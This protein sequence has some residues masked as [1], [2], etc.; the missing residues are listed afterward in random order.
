M[1]N[2]LVITTATLGLVMLAFA[3]AAQANEEAE[4]KAVAAAEAWLGLIDKD[5]FAKSWETAASLFKGAVTQEQWEQKVGPVRTP[6]GEVVSRRAALTRYE[7]SLPGAP[8]GEY[9][10]IQ[11]ETVFANKAST[12]ETVTPMR[13]PDGEWRVGGY[14]IK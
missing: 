9:V 8:D 7:T 5:D 2:R 11:F 10:V 13:D 12:V 3:P 6:L 1:Q 14:F 4:K